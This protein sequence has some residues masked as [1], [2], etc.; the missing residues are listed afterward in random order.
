MHNVGAIA[1]ARYCGDY[2][3]LALYVIE[4]VALSMD[5]GAHSLSSL[6]QLPGLPEN[7]GPAMPET[8]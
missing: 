2:T 1:K 5:A 8:L 7:E 6:S 3:M 4:Y